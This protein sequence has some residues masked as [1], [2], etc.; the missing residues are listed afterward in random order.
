MTRLNVVITSVLAFVSGYKLH[1]L[2]GTS[3]TST[4]A[5][6]AAIACGLAAIL[7]VWRLARSAPMRPAN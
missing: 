7:G 3:D 1:G 2:V 5:W 4:S 6:F